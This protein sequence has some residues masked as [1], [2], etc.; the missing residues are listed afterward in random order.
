MFDPR[1]TRHTVRLRLPQTEQTVLLSGVWG[2]AQ[3]VCQLQK[4]PCSGS[5]CGDSWKLK[6]CLGKW[7]CTRGELGAALCYS[8]QLAEEPASKAWSIRRGHYIA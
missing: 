8:I 3:T 7:D 6:G 5:V 2:L 4:W 1:V